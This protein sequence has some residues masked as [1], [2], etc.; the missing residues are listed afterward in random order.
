MSVYAPQRLVRGQDASAQAE[1]LCQG[2]SLIRPPACTPPPPF[3]TSFI[4][5]HKAIRK[6]MARLS[7]FH[8]STRNANKSGHVKPAVYVQSTAAL[9]CF[10]PGK[11]R[12]TKWRWLRACGLMRPPC[13]RKTRLS[14]LRLKLTFKTEMWTPALVGRSSLRARPRIGIGFH[15]WAGLT[16]FNK[17][18]PT[19]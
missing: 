10:S 11:E 1:V 14:S 2:M 18:Q 5:R 7:F 17:V 16:S 4:R 12:G 13:W 15:K 8:P 9:K 3:T 6:F 19:R